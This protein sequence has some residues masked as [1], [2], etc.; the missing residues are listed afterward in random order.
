MQ[1]G[2]P[3]RCRLYFS[4]NRRYA[5]A[6]G[7]QWMQKVTICCKKRGLGY[8]RDQYESGMGDPIVA[9]RTGFVE[10]QHAQLC[11]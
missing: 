9:G 1:A 11:I 3:S 4:G 8:P 2:V 6:H 7:V 5:A 10:I